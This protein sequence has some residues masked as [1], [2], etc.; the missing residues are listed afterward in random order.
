MARTSG[1][2]V[3]VETWHVGNK[4]V[5]KVTVRDVNGR[6]NGATNYRGS[7]ISK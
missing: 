7:V 4:T 2:T 6:F 1:N 5:S 3:R